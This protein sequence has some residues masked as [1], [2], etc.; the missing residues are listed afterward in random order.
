MLITWMPSTLPASAVASKM[1][2]RNGV[3]RLV[4]VRATFDVPDITSINQWF[5]DLARGLRKVAHHSD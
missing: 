3:V 1:L 5:K 4:L 2:H